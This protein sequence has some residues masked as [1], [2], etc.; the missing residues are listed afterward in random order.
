[1]DRSIGI[2]RGRFNKKNQKQKQKQKL[3]PKTK[4]SVPQ[5]VVVRKNT[6]VSV[7]QMNPYLDLLTNPF[8]SASYGSK[9]PDPFSP[10]TSTYRIHSEFKVTTPT[11][12]T[13]AAY[14]IRPN[15][16]QSI[17]DL[18]AFSGGS[19]TSGGNTG[20]TAL[21]SNSMIYAATTPTALSA[22]L[23]SYR[24]VSHGIRIRLME[25]QQVATGRLIIGRA[26]RSRPDM[27]FASTNNTALLW[28]AVGSA[29]NSFLGAI[30]GVVANSPF[31]LET[32]E[33]KEFSMYDLMGL[34]IT[35]VNSINSPAALMFSPVYSSA[36][37]NGVATLVEV[38]DAPVNAGTGVVT[39]ANNTGSISDNQPGW[40]DMY[41]YMDGLPSGLY[42]AINIEY[43]LHLEGVPQ[44][45]STTAISAVPSH[46]PARRGE[47]L[48]LDTIMKKSFQAA[49]TICT[50]APTA[51]N[52]IFPGRNL[53]KDAA[54]VGGMMIKAAPLLLA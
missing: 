6:K 43:I 42:P 29:G 35:Q 16:F 39:I 14:L 49:K 19:S 48:G 54:A 50:S 8:N 15:P 28:G 7:N 30:P 40:D 20:W 36:V 34:D 12:I 41:I 47:F 3:Q 45:A 4:P 10:H 46:P 2:G 27:P 22:I 13:T 38:T 51:Y 23:T 37:L 33:A 53:K 24:V 25:P 9:V 18:Q 17:I 44:I 1:M 31:L 26:P 21:T 52:N 5:T 11:N 32:T